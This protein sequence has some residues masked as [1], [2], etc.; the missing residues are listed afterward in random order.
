MHIFLAYNVIYIFQ[1]YFTALNNRN[2]TYQGNVSYYLYEDNGYG[3]MFIY[4]SPELPMQV[5]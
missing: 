3:H 1:L 4:L 5:R 2:L